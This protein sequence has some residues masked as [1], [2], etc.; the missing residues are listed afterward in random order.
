MADGKTLTS[1]NMCTD[2]AWKLQGEMFFAS[3]MLLR[4]GGCDM[5]L[6]IQWLYAL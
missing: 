6:G 5:V 4:L 1:D 3:V 2:F